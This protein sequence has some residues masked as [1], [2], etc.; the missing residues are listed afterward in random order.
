MQR[1]MGWMDGLGGPRGWDRWSAND[2]LPQ[3]LGGT[4]TQIYRTT[5]TPPA[6][7]ARLTCMSL[8]G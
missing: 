8:R 6:C 3:S 1:R 7:I 2:E 4:G 5:S